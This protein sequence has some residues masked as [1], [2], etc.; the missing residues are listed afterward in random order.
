M[1]N[2]HPTQSGI[3]NSHPEPF[4]A[5]LADALRFWEPRRLFYNLSLTAV[6][7]FSLVDSWPHF[8]PAF[9]LSSLPPLLGLGL[10]AN[11]CYCAAYL[12]DLSIQL[13]S[14]ASGWRRRRWILW[15]IGTLFA[16]VLATYWIADEIY[17]D[18]S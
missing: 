1:Q 11:L 15:V 6:A 9:K 7:V 2:P 3:G 12:V 10:I 16:M 18:F 4:R 5:V 14:P 17:P 13:S 8:R